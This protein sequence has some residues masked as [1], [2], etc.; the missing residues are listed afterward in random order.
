MLVITGTNQETREFGKFLANYLNSQDTVLLNGELGVGKTVL[1]S[2]IVEQR[3]G[4]KTVRSPSYTYINT[5]GEGENT[6]HHIDLYLCDDEEDIRY[7]GIDDC[8]ERGLSLIEWGNK[9]PD[10]WGDE[11]W[12]LTL[13][14][15]EDGTRKIEISA[16]EKARY[17]LEEMKIKWS[18]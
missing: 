10:Y 17:L 7:I 1:A 3:T 9:F 8:L 11:I 16:P 12:Q 6:V 5:Y 2:G 4:V 13:S 15:Q 14:Y 18:H